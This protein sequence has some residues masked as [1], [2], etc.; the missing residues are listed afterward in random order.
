VDLILDQVGGVAVNG[1]YSNGMHVAQADLYQYL[2]K[3]GCVSTRGEGKRGEG[4]G[5][6]PI[7]QTARMMPHQLQQS[8]VRAVT[9]VLSTI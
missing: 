1:D 9:H 8:F 3:A 5:V 2:F 4:T 7:S 6:Y